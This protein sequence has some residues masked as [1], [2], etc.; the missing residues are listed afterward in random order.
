M[1]V[2]TEAEIEDVRRDAP[3]PRRGHSYDPTCGCDECEPTPHNEEAT[4]D[5]D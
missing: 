1:H 5:A 3:P 2:A 4:D